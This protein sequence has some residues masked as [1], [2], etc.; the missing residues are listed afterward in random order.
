MPT[1]YINI[2]GHA[3]YMHY[4]G[5]TTLPEVIPDFSNAAARSS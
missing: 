5:Q 1:K 4:A 3:V 2:N